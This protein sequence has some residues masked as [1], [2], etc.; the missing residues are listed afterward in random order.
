MFK[1]PEDQLQ[2]QISV[3]EDTNPFGL[4]QVA[5]AL[6]FLFI[7]RS[8]H[9]HHYSRYYEKMPRKSDQVKPTMHQMDTKL[10]I[11]LVI[12][13]YNEAESLPELHA[14]IVRVMKANNFS[15]EVIF[16]DDGSSD[17]SWQVIQKLKSNDPNVRG[18]RFRRNY[19]KSAG[20]NVGFELIKG[21]SS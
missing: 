11:S 4:A 5:L 9:S 2:E 8:T 1:L 19:G 14:W 3:I 18:V 7:S 10:D 17:G 15:Y 20:L 21:M 13:L 6:P 16:V 12:P